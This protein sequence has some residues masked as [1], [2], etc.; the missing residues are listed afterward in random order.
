MSDHSWRGDYR[1]GTD[2]LGNV[3]GWML[4]Y[5][6]RCWLWFLPIWM[7]VYMLCT[8]T[9]SGH[10]H[11]CY[12]DRRADKVSSKSI[13]KSTLFSPA[14]LRSGLCAGS[15]LRKEAWSSLNHFTSDESFRKINASM[16]FLLQCIQWGEDD[17]KWKRNGVCV[18]AKVARHP[19]VNEDEE[20]MEAVAVNKQQVQGA[21]ASSAGLPL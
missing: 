17:T 12:G 15:I 1:R 21:K 11:C 18:C 2:W 3:G 9:G 6:G 4:I 7:A 14:Q 19:N 20:V 16:F 13:S 5:T 8:L 10:Y